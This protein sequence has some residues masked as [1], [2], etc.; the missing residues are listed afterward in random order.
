MSESNL[1]SSVKYENEVNIKITSNDAQKQTHD[2][3]APHYIYLAS[4][5]TPTLK[6][7]RL[8]VRRPSYM[9]YIEYS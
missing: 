2:N 4:E 1:K 5:V 3:Y 7:T 9:Q 8:K 6:T